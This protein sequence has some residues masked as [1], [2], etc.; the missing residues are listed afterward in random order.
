MYAVNNKLLVAIKDVYMCSKTFII[1]NYN[2]H[3]SK[4]IDLFDI[5]KMQ[6]KGMSCD[7][8]CLTCL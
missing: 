1:G 7:H 5:K 8:G 2:L 3:I 6:G 4:L